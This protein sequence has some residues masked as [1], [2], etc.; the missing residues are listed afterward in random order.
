MRVPLSFLGDGEYNSVL[1]RDGVASDAVVVVANAKQK[2]G[3]MLT[4]ELHPG[5]GFLARFSKQ[6]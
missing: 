6:L 2:R 3:D 4:I 1:V 5:G